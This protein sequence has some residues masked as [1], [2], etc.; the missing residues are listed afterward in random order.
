MAKGRGTL[1]KF[2]LGS[3]D[4]GYSQF[5]SLALRRPVW[6]EGPTVPA[7]H[8]CNTCSWGG[9]VIVYIHL[10]QLSHKELIENRPQIVWALHTA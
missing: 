1:R 4:S 9:W 10:G 3:L 5:P 8:P 6:A 7:A 2:L